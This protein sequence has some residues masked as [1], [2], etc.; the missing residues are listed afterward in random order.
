MTLSKSIFI[1]GI[2]IVFVFLFGIA[3]IVAKGASTWPSKGA[4]GSGLFVETGDTGQLKLNQLSKTPNISRSRLV[5]IDF[6]QLGDAGSGLTLFAAHDTLPLNLFT[7]TI[8]TAVLERVVQNPSGSYSWIG[9]L[10]GISHSQAIFVVMDGIMTG[11]IIAPP[12]LYRIRHVG[13]GVHSIQQ[14]D[15]RGFSGERYI[16]STDHI[17]LSSPMVL[18]SSLESR[19]DSMIVSLESPALKVPALKSNALAA[20]VIDV[21][22]AY[23]P[24]ARNK[25]GGTSE[26]TTLID[27]M[28]NTANQSYINSGINQTLR[29]VHTAE[30]NYVESGASADL[31]ALHFGVVDNISILRDT[32]SADLVSLLIDDRNMDHA[33]WSGI[34]DSDA[35]SVIRVLDYGTS[36]TFAH[37]LGHNMRAGHDWYVEDNT[38]HTFGHGYIAPQ[39]QWMTIMAYSDRCDAQG[40]QWC[41]QVPYWSNPDLA[42]EGIPMG[43]PEGTSL[44]CQKGNLD[45]PPCDA[46]NRK[47]LNSTAEEIARYREPATFDVSMTTD[48]LVV[49]TTTTTIGFTIKVSNHGSQSVTGLQ[50]VNRIPSQTT[51]AGGLDQ[52]GIYENGEIVWSGSLG[53]YRYALLPFQV[54]VPSGTLNEGDLIINILRISSNEANLMP[55]EFVTIVSPKSVFLP[56]LISQ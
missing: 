39:G 42:Y 15:P 19:N 23:T 46:D 9:H 48:P 35:H 33:G 27:L 45:N 41:F 52:G 24:A 18:T 53:G 56:A 1:G 37:E 50:I 17:E 25:A 5:T 2:F 51:F 32:Y 30:V 20:A 43:V 22:V 7:D 47:V 13:G 38:P 4:I 44:N 26:I 21:L 40:G 6:G 34:A 36:L 3:P 49:Q 29:L 8:L 14:V 11:E 16:T 31:S 54:T 55:T 12:A 10:E 28:V